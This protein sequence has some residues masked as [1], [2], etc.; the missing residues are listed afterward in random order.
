MLLLAG[1]LFTSTLNSQTNEAINL[2]SHKSFSEYHEGLFPW[3]VVSKESRLGFGYY[4]ELTLNRFV[5]RQEWSVGT[6]F[7]YSYFMLSTGFGYRIAVQ[8]AIR[9]LAYPPQLNLRFGEGYNTPPG[10]QLLIARL[11]IGVD[12]Y[13]DTQN[14]YIKYN[15]RF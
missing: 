8:P 11:G 2:V 1:S 13:R 4:G 3:L 7:E 5:V 9:I 15:G 12:F 14:F 10:I 6:D